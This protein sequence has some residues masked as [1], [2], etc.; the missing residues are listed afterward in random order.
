MTD[1]SD[2]NLERAELL[3]D[4]LTVY[5]PE[6]LPRLNVVVPGNQSALVKRRISCFGVRIIDEEEFI[7]DLKR[8]RKQDGW[9]KQMV[10]KLAAAAQSS[11]PFCLTLD[12]DLVCLRPMVPNL[13]VENGRALF[14]PCPNDIP[15][16]HFGWY[17]DSAKLLGFKMQRGDIVGSVTPAILASKIV[18]ALIEHLQV[19]H[20]MPWVR[21]LMKV[22]AHNLPDRLPFLRRLNWSEYALYNT[23]SMTKGLHNL[24]HGPCLGTGESPNLISPDSLWWKEEIPNWSAAKF[25]KN[26]GKSVFGVVQSNT[27]ISAAMVRAGFSPF[28][29]RPPT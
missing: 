9:R 1:Y 5:F 12:A 25:F 14:Q 10:I 13:L 7:P 17:R 18:L 11:E 15:P 20:S 26:Q 21:L 29:I 8:F 3:L 2:D 27:R 6:L 23:F 28:L 4:S 22:A 16:N 19:R 24:H